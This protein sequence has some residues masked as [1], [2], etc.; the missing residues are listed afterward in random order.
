MP[1]KLD[2]STGVITSTSSLT[3][4][5]VLFAGAGGGAIQDN[6]NFFW[7][8]TNNYL[9]I[10]TASPSQRLTVG[11]SASASNY[12][13]GTVAGTYGILSDTSIEMYGSASAQTMV[14]KVNG[15]VER[16]RIDASG[17]LGIGVAPS[18]WNGSFRAI[19]IGRIGSG[20]TANTSNGNTSYVANAFLNS[21]S[22]WTYASNGFA[23]R[24][25]FDVG[26][27]AYL[28]FN[29][30]SGTAGA[31]ISFTQAMTL[32]ASGRLGIGT[33]N[34]TALFHTYGN[35]NGASGLIIQ[36]ASS[37]SS[38]YSSLQFQGDTASFQFA[39]W[40]ST[41]GG[42]LANQAWLYTNQ[43]NSLVLG[44]NNT[45]RLTIDAS[46]NLGLGVTPNTT[47][48]AAI[49]AFQFGNA[50][51]MMISNSYDVYFG[52]NFYYSTGYKYLNTGY[53]SQYYQNVGAHYWLTAPSG[54]AN[55]AISFTQAMTL[56]ASGNVGIN[57]TSTSFGKLAINSVP[58]S[59]WSIDLAP[60]G[61]SNLIT[62]ANNAIYDMLPSCSGM[63]LLQENSGTFAAIVMCQYGAVSIVWQYG[64][65]LSNAGV[66]TAG[67]LNL[68]YNAATNS[69]RFQ[70]LYG[71]TLY[72]IICS[73]KTRNSA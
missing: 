22:Q 29:A 38:A 49:K 5:S 56:D 66:N 39:Q 28:W 37:G 32:D 61:S 36:N 53:A 16:M 1:I 70:N 40:S 46:G 48:N 31:A 44:T 23:L 25:V 71:S 64:S 24:H 13:L 34:P 52:S 51:V 30:P 72:P 55:A 35:T 62:L 2:G 6:T 14:F 21:S 3:T 68:Y 20:F 42:G 4:G 15:A 73:F 18:A 63:I 10:G 9:G 8:D 57:T 17:N 11:G 27:N 26:S 19:E 45:A 33:T 69:Y 12:F 59:Q 60:P 54:T 43:A 47:W 58:S 65:V 41:T 7:D 50:G 67:K